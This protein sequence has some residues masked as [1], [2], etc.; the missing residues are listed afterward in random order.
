MTAINNVCSHEPF[1]RG[2]G[3]IFE[4]QIQ[5]IFTAKPGSQTP[6]GRLVDK[7]GKAWRKRSREGLPE[8][9]WLIS[10]MESS[11][12]G[13]TVDALVLTGDEGRDKLR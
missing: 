1:L 3:N 2:L 10:R 4:S 7:T 8:A 6:G 13:H 11:F 9:A 5:L 12:K